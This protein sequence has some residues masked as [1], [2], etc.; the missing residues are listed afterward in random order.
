MVAMSEQ[1]AGNPTAADLAAITD[2]IER[3]NAAIAFL[4]TERQ[5][6]RTVEA[7]RD[8]AIRQAR[9][10]DPT[11]TIDQLALRLGVGRH[12]VVDAGRPHRRITGQ[13][14]SVTS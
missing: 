9:H 2:P 7:L 1:R 4:D 8:E 5:T 3:A 6:I 14:E 11:L 12:I 10:M 13:K